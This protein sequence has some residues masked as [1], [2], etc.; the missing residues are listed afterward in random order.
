MSHFK[1]FI[2]QI[3][4]MWPRIGQGLPKVTSVIGEDAAWEPVVL[5]SIHRS[6]SLVLKDKS[7]FNVSFTLRN[8][9]IL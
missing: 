5:S 4:K 2:L 9:E 7:V 8:Q 6:V 1:S 3:K